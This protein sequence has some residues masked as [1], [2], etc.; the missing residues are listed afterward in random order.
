ML[1]APKKF[2]LDTNLPLHSIQR[3]SRNY[4]TLGGQEPL[5]VTGTIVV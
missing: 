2:V 5:T 1:L 3:R 4:R